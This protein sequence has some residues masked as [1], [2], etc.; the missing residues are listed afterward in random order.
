MSQECTNIRN[1]DTVIIYHYAYENS[2]EVIEG[3][4]R[5]EVLMKYSLNAL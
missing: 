5:R 2:K 4:C 1:L 3:M